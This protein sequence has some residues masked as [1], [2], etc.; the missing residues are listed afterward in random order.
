[1]KKINFKKSTIALLL[2]FCGILFTF[3]C[4]KEVTTSTA[5]VTVT[6]ANNTPIL[7]A[8]VVLSID[9]T[10]ATGDIKPI[11]DSLKITDA[12][13]MATYTFD[14]EAI[15]TATAKAVVT[16]SVSTDTLTGIVRLKFEE[17]KVNNETLIVR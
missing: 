11:A 17:G 10:T 1:M 2:A 14:Y 4:K 13:G 16:D 9:G 6:D 12:S 7:G 5:V 15:Y 3:S 8:T